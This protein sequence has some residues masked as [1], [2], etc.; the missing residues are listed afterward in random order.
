PAGTNLTTTTRAE[1]KIV[2]FISKRFLLA[3]TRYSATEREAWAILRCLEEVRWLVLGS[4][5]STKVF[6]DHQA[7]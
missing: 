4:T 2:M 5:F 3:E 1:M 6:T 7:L